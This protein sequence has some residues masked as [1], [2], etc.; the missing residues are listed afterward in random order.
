MISPCSQCILAITSWHQ[1]ISSCVQTSPRTLCRSGERSSFPITSSSRPSMN[2]ESRISRLV[3]SRRVIILLFKRIQIRHVQNITS[4][5]SSMKIC[6]RAAINDSYINIR[7]NI[8]T[9]KHTFLRT[10]RP[11]TP[12]G[13]P[14]ESNSTPRSALCACWCDLCRVLIMIHDVLT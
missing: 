12:S 1:A 6:T 4:D 13:S 10:P 3:V 7:A 5:S 11:S 8:H 9:C 14:Y 2:P